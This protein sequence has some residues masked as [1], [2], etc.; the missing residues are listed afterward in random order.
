MGAVEG[1]GCASHAT[2]NT[3]RPTSV[4]KRTVAI[5]TRLLFVIGM[6]NVTHRPWSIGEVEIPSQ[7]ACLVRAAELS[8]VAFVEIIWPAVQMQV[9]SSNRSRV[10]GKG[11]PLLVNKSFVQSDHPD[12]DIVETRCLLPSLLCGRSIWNFEVPK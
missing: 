1:P 2:Q 6:P 7:S 8:L 4:P 10:V 12:S 9:W 11:T 3:R 5:M